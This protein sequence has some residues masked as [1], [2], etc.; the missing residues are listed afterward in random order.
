M[1]IHSKILLL[2]NLEEKGGKKNIYSELNEAYLIDSFQPSL[3]LVF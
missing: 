3:P 1:I 2:Y